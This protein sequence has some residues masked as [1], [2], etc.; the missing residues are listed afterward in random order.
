MPER[1]TTEQDKEAN[2]HL[3]PCIIVMAG[4]PLMAKSTLGKA[5]AEQTNAVYLDVDEARWEIFPRTNK[6]GT[7]EEE[8]TAMRESY[9]YNHLR[10]HHYLSENIPVILGAT[11][12]WEGYHEMLKEL[13][14]VTGAPLRVFLLDIADEELV[15][16]V[17]KRQAEG[18]LS[19]VQSPEVALKLKGRYQPIEGVW[20]M[21]LD[22]N[23]PVEENAQ[24][25]INALS[26]LRI[27]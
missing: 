8:R 26:D 11:Y 10:A 12:S 13:T 24:R 18:D 27:S 25:V 22:G 19:V 5:L 17:E 7:D 15:R 14:Q 4:P 1:K 20:R 9:Q 3:N 23:A 16:R 21:D 2:I 6:R